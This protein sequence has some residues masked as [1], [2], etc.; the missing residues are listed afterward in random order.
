MHE[1]VGHHEAERREEGQEERRIAEPRAR[2][3]PR[4]DDGQQ[5]HGQEHKEIDLRKT[6]EAQEPPRGECPPRGAAGACHQPGQHPGH[7][8]TLRDRLGHR[9]LR[10]PD[11]RQRDGR[12]RGREPGGMHAAQPPRD[13]PQANQAQGREE[14]CDDKRGARRA[15]GMSQGG[16]DRKQRGKTGGDR[17][18]GDVGDQEAAG[19]S[20]TNWPVASKGTRFRNSSARLAIDSGRSRASSNSSAPWW[21]I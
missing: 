8:E 3:Q 6:G 21:A 18:V 19:E 17:G 15:D 16:E 1:V 13:A 10:E 5:E 11:L 9:E 12:E 14:G 7:H 20:C 2:Q 4:R